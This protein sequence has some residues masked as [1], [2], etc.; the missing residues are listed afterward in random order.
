MTLQVHITNTQHLVDMFMGRS[1]VGEKERERE[2]I[3]KE[4]KNK[5]FKNMYDIIS[6][7]CKII[8]SYIHFI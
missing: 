5:D 7:T 4:N 3:E 2:M 1:D 6:F 8:C